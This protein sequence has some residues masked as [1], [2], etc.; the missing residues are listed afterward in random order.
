VR[1][2]LPIQSR[3]GPGTHGREPTAAPAAS[4]GS[5]RPTAHC[6]VASRQCYRPGTSQRRRRGMPWLRSGIV[7]GLSCGTTGLRQRLEH[8]LGDRPGGRSSGPPTTP[9]SASGTTSATRSRS[10][11]STR[12]QPGPQ[13]W[14]SQSLTADTTTGTSRSCTPTTMRVKPY[15]TGSSPRAGDPQALNPA[16]PPVSPPRI[17]KRRQWFDN[18]RRRSLLADERIR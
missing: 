3:Q 1:P 14:T 8:E 11:Q 18:A 12:Y 5:H 2:C 6:A 16:L 17:L 9:M 7:R 15:W 10:C 4:S 13:C